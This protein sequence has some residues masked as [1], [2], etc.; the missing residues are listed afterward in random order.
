MLISRRI[1]MTSVN[2]RAWRRWTENTGCESLMKWAKKHGEQKVPQT[3]PSMFWFRTTCCSLILLTVYQVVRCLTRTRRLVGFV[4]YRYCAN[5]ISRCQ[6]IA[7][8]CNNKK[9]KTVEFSDTKIWA[10]IVCIYTSFVPW[11]VVYNQ[12]LPNAP[13]TVDVCVFFGRLLRHIGECFWT[14]F[15]IKV[16]TDFFMKVTKN[17]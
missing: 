12:V 10:C 17:D 7:T 11:I 13:K 5:R 3:S 4:S 14:F 1:K 9:C 8:K 15:G 2:V 16:A 6:V